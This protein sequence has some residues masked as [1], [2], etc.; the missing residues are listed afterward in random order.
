MFFVVAEFNLSHPVT[1]GEQYT[2]YN[3]TIANVNNLTSDEVS[4]EEYGIHDLLE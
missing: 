3:T 2:S 1:P 4:S